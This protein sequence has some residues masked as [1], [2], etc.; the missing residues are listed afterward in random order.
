MFCMFCKS[1]N[2]VD[3]LNIADDNSDALLVCNECN[4]II[5]TVCYTAEVHAFL[6]NKNVR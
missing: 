2:K 6:E 1:P 5:G 3:I 4:K